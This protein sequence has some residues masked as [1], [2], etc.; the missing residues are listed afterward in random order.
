MLAIRGLQHEA[1]RRLCEILQLVCAEALRKFDIPE[2]RLESGVA[3]VVPNT[4]PTL[5]ELVSKGYQVVK[6]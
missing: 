2:D 4:I 1:G 3:E 5:A 6:Y